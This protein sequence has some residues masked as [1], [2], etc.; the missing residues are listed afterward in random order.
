[1]NGLSVI[2]VDVGGTFT[3]LVL[4]EP[5]GSVTLGKVPS[6]PENQAT[7]VMAGLMSV[8]DDVERIGRVA[9]GTTV[10]TNALIEGRG[11]PVALLTTSGFGDLLEIGRTRRMLPSLYDPSFVRPAPLVPR[12]LRIEIAERLTADGAALTPLDE[13]A[14]A[15][16]AERIGRAA[17]AVA[18]CFLHSWRDDRHERRASDILR[19]LMPG[20]FVTTSAEVV[21]EFREYE[22]FSTAVIN[23]SLMPV[24]DHYLGA[25]DDSLSQAGCAGRLVTMDSAGGTLDT[26]TARRLPVRTILSGPAGGV[27]GALWI[28]E[29]TDLA[30]F[31]TCDMGGT[32]TDVCVIEAMCPA[33]VSETAIAGYPLKGMQYDINTV[34]AGGGSIAYA[35]ADDI[36][37][38]GP[39]SAGAEPGPASYG[40]GGTEPTVTDA[41]LILGRLGTARTFG[42]A[43]KPDR[44]LA[45]D[46]VAS[47]AKRLGLEMEVL[48]EGIV[49]LAVMRM[50]GAVRAITVERGRDPADFALMPFGGAG[51]MHACD[52]GEELGIRDILVPI[53]PGNLS[54]LGLVASDYRQELVRTCVKRL[55]ECDEIELRK[56]LSEQEKAGRNLDMV[57]GTTEERIRFEH[58]L[59][60]RYARQAFEITISLPAVVPAMPELRQLFLDVYR[61][62]YGQADPT[63]AIEIVNLRTVVVGLVDRPS[64]QALPPVSNSPSPVGSRRLWLRGAQS[65]WPVYDRAALSAGHAF[66]GPAVIEEANATTVVLPDWAVTMDR[67]GNLRLKREGGRP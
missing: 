51:P 58:A 57:A 55:D 24:M 22:R 49:R 27:A 11:A 32:S 5:D 20:V 38:V 17:R 8:T 12:P 10:S 52:L 9:H 16:A 25:L 28:A 62:L 41:N 14:V 34:G 18:V 54:A 2:G 35:E 66:A 42:A 46:A 15:A 64:P 19:R 23:A 26:G 48:A 61:K 40:R 31:I 59:D 4:L 1:M 29:S 33:V 60:M 37:N 6:T 45:E 39:Q 47:L 50:A 21:P 3:D 44:R 43:I 36:L 7:G 13:D 30:D 65:D 53:C 56:L 67:W 63:G